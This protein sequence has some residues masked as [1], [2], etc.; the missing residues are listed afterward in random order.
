M[1]FLG[2]SFL[3]REIEVA[4]A[5]FAHLRIDVPKRRASLD[6]P[7]SK[8]DPSAVGCTRTWGCTCA[9]AVPAEDCVYHAAAEHLVAVRKVLGVPTGDPLEQAM[10]LFPDA[11]GAT[12]TKAA[13]VSTIE[14][15]AAAAG[16]S[17]KDSAGQRRFGGHSLRVSG[18]HW[19][20]AL[21]FS[22]DQVK[23]FGRWAS[24][25]VL[26]YLGE[27]HVSDLARSRRRLIRKHGLIDR[28]PPPGGARA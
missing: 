23:T 4:Y 15:L 22:V 5:R 28:A 16:E 14:A 18:A 11:A 19:L 9:S 21:G 20:G 25:T 8:T 27:T 6:L 13:M 2:A 10:P 17:L 1:F 12:I 24:D 3:L 7:V 26:R